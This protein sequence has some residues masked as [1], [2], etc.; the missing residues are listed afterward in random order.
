MDKK[1]F[2]ISGCN[3]SGKTTAAQVL[4]PTVFERTEFVN[5]DNIARQISPDDPGAKAIEAGR[6]ML[7]RIDELLDQGKSFT[8]ETTLSTRSHK[9]LINKA[10]NNGY[11]VMLVFFW[12]NSPDLA[13][14]RV[15]QRVSRGGHHI[16]SDVIRRRYVKGIRNLFD[17]FIPICDIWSIY[18][19][20]INPRCMIASGTK[21]N[22]INVVDETKFNLIKLYGQ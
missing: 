15:A 13:I 16:P 19:N 1:L 22:M 11:Q 3:G 14:D 2:I 8:I 6:L 9:S 18:D 20:S 17:I 10:H 21:N 5:A 4:I 7:Q 12:L